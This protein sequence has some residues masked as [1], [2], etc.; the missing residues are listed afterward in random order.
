MMHQSGRYAVVARQ[1]YRAIMLPYV[2]PSLA[3][4]VVLPNEID[5]LENVMLRIDAQE[6]SALLARFR[7]NPPQVSV[8]VALPRFKVESDL[9]LI[10]PYE[11][12]GMRLA[13]DRDRADFSGMAGKPS[14][15]GGFVIGAIKH[16]AMIDVTEE[17][18]EAAAVAAVEMPAGAAAPRPEPIE[19]FRVD[20]PFLFYL[21]DNA[22]GAILFVGRVSSPPQFA[23]PVSIQTP[24]PLPPPPAP[25]PP[26]MV[27]PVKCLLVAPIEDLFLRHGLLGI[28]AWD[29]SKPASGNNN[30]YFV[31]RAIDA[32]H[33]QRD[34]MTGATTRAWYGII[35]KAE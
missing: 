17:S 25:L 29:C 20:H 6:Q 2:I 31:N 5:G 21:A 24:A 7:A 23:G 22:T 12:A 9:D 8:A 28:F 26:T 34:Y 3:L 10:P 1:D 32:D 4:I 14:A 35:D 30:W 16:R 19:D 33:I 15:D 27:G 18:S 11:K 13:F